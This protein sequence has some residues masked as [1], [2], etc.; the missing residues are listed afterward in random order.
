LVTEQCKPVYTFRNLVS[1]RNPLETRLDTKVETYCIML[2]LTCY[3]KRKKKKKKT[4]N[5]R[6]G[7]TTKRPM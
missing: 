2:A 7:R 3:Y 5:T 6:Q 1:I 4:P